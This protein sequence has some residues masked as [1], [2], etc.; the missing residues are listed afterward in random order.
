MTKGAAVLQILRSE[1]ASL[2]IPFLNIERQAEIIEKGFN[3]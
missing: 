3:A 1:L 2:S